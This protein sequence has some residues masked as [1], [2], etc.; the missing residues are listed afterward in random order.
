MTDWVHVNWG[1]GGWGWGEAVSQRSGRRLR[2]F[3]VL[4][5][6]LSRGSLGRIEQPRCSSDGQLCEKAQLNACG[7]V[8]ASCLELPR[9][10]TWC[11]FLRICRFFCPLSICIFILRREKR[12]YFGNTNPNQT[13]PPHRCSEMS[14]SGQ[15]GKD[16]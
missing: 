7:A 11:H 16:S 6:K 3:T 4:R 2:D 14:L 9:F 8:L 5:P 13:F 1:V 15:V 10:A 12:G